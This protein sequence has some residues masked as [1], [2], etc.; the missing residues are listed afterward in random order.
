MSYE[1]SVLLGT[2]FA[3]YLW[4]GLGVLLSG[5]INVETEFFKWVTCVTYAMVA[6]L[7]VRIIILPVGLLEEVPLAVRLVA[8]LVAVFVMMRLPRPW[9]GLV[10]GLLVGSV[11]VALGYSLSQLT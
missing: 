7:V 11:L 4:R 3:T 1:L 6:A 9:G 8:L 5:R 2:I 10:P